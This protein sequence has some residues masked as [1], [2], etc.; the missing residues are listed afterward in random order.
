MYDKRKEDVKMA[1]IWAP[2]L[3]LVAVLCSAIWANAV[4]TDSNNKV[5]IEQ[6]RQGGK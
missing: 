6:V 2:A 5:K 1:A 4:I 3:V